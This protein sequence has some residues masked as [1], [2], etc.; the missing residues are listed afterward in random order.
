MLTIQYYTVQIKHLNSCQLC[1]YA[2]GLDLQ[3]ISC[4]S[5][6]NSN[7]LNTVPQRMPI[8]LQNAQIM[9]FLKMWWVW[10]RSEEFCSPVAGLSSLARSYNLV[11]S[12]GNPVNAA[13]DLELLICLNQRLLEQT[14]MSKCEILSLIITSA[15]YQISVSPCVNTAEGHSSWISV[16][17]H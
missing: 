7:S 3:S 12:T 10:M 13:Q 11:G 2:C 15:T 6:T 16:R 9:S 17:L 8:Y 5:S 14:A 4:I 1:W